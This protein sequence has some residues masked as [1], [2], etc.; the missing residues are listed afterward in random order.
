M[1]H[2]LYPR[3][4]LPLLMLLNNNI[5]RTRVG[6]GNSVGHL[7][8]TAGRKPLVGALVR[9]VTLEEVRDAGLLLACYNWRVGTS[10]RCS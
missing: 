10:H 4:G 9:M 6:L 5:K 7:T 2:Y 8:I 1:L 3:H